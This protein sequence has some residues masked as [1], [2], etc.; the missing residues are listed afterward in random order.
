M[1]IC[2]FQNFWELNHIST[3]PSRGKASRLH[4]TKRERVKLNFWKHPIP[5]VLSQNSSKKEA[6]VFII[7]RWELK[8]LQK[9]LKGR[10]KK[11]L[12]SF[13]KSPKKVLITSSLSYFIPNLPMERWCN[14]AKKRLT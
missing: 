13:P 4:F 14:Y 12:F 3:K 8:I 7:S 5:K 1:Q 9:K 11:G 2:F 6:K 10:K